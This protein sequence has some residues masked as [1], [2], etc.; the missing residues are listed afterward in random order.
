MALYELIYISK[1]SENFQ[2]EDLVKML[3]QART[4]NLEHEITGLLAYKNQE[5]LQVIEGKKNKIQR[6]FDNINND[7][8]HRNVKVIWEESIAYR[9]FANW[10]MGLDRKSVV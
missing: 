8:R 10:Q 5:F 2:E 1:A 4:A 9:S 7:E 6:L 3:N